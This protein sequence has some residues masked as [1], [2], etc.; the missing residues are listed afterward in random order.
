V[1]KWLEG[2]LGTDWSGG[3]HAS[4][5][6]GGRSLC[7]SE[8]KIED[9]SLH[10]EGELTICTKKVQIRLSKL[11][12]PIWMLSSEVSMIIINSM[13]IFASG[14]CCKDKNHNLN[15]S[16]QAFEAKLRSGLESV[17]HNL[18]MYLHTAGHR[19]GKVADQLYDLKNIEARY[20]ARTLSGPQWR[21]VSS[22]LLG[23]AKLRSGSQ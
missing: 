1:V 20:V 2:L 15:R 7:P 22:L 19:H 8:K 17:R 5:L 23:W 3:K 21:P 10:I 6:N 4:G 18:K 12:D 11:L 14:V 9:A 13:C 16:S